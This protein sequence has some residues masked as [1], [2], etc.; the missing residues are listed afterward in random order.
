MRTFTDAELEELI[1]CPKEVVEP[2]RREMR[3]DGKMKRND[4]GLKSKDGKHVFRAF[5]RQ[6][7]DFPENF[8]LGLMYQ[9]GEEPGS[10]QLL[11]CNGQHG[12]ERVHPHHAVFHIHRSKAEDINAGILEP[13]EIEQAASYA[14]F[15]EALAHFCSLIQLDR[16][17]DYFPGLT[18]AILFP[19]GEG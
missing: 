11:R 16:P 14:S 3:I 12:G 18:Q 7:D 6:S 8:S 5:L 10:F 4:M 1:R 13:R 19:E 2:P 17:D 9:P 15:R